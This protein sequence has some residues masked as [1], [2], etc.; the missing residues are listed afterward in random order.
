MEKG[1]ARSK[2]KKWE[3]WEIPT[4]KPLLWGCERVKWGWKVETPKRHIQIPLLN[5]LTKFQLPSSIWR[6]DKEGTA[7]FKVKKGWNPHISPPNWLGSWFLDMLY[8]FW[9]AI[10]WLKKGKNL[11]VWPFSTSYTELGHN[12]ILTQVHPHS[13]SSNLPPNLSQLTELERFWPVSNGVN[14]FNVGG[15]K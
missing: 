15:K 2:L 11:H 10:N 7:F 8:N 6:G 12:C 1:Y 5:L 3:K 14:N 9:F 13:Y 4:K